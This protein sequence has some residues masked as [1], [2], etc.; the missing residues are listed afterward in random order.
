MDEPY[1]YQRTKTASQFDR[2]LAKSISMAK[3]Q[4]GAGWDHLTHD[5]QVAFVC[6]NLVGIIGGMDWDHFDN[7]TPEQAASLVQKL[8]DISEACLKANNL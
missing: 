2:H 8:K 4:W 6:R 1:G 3:A 7:A 5:M